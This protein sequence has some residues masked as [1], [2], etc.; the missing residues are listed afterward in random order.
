MYLVHLA[1]FQTNKYSI[2]FY[3]LLLLPGRNKVQREIH[4]GNLKLQNLCVHSLLIHLDI[5]CT[6]V[7][8]LSTVLLSAVS[9]IKS[10]PKFQ[11]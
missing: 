7:P 2:K 4:W 11:K 8:Y 9:V 10:E 5:C 3:L 6:A 1:D